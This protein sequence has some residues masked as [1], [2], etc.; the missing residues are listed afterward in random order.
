M[1]YG[2][3]IFAGAVSAVIGVK[4]AAAQFVDTASAGNGGVATA[5]GNGGAVSAGDIN[6]GGNVGSAI[7]IG[8]TNGP[9]PDVYGGDILN[10]TALGVEVDGGTAIAD[11]TGGNNNLAFV[12]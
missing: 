10:S 5:S 9:D 12:S 11:A 3:G 2:K 6:S 7:A 1:K 8:D 4:T